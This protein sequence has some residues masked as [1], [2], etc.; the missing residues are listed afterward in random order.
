MD[1]VIDALPMSVLIG[2]KYVMSKSEKS[3]QIV[4][5]EFL[6]HRSMMM[7]EIITRLESVERR[8]F[9]TGFLSDSVM[10]WAQEEKAAC[11]QLLSFKEVFI[12][13]LPTG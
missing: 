6:K 2:L 5:S 13:V 9:I 12:G 1:N 3:P 7:D 11:D 8:D 4:D 10:K